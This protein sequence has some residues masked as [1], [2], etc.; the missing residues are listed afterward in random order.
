MVT[1]AVR[2]Q[3]LHAVRSEHRQAAAEYLHMRPVLIDDEILC[4]ADPSPVLVLAELGPT[5]DIVLDLICL[6]LDKFRELVELLRQINGVARCQLVEQGQA[7]AEQDV[8]VCLLLGLDFILPLLLLL[9]FKCLLIFHSAVRRLL[10][11]HFDLQLF[12]RSG[13]FDSVHIG[14]GCL[15]ALWLEYEVFSRLLP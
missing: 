6:F 12:L 14:S 15:L 4:L 10:D 7:L 9:F 2:L 1:V 5:S 3:L 13:R 8:L 11:L